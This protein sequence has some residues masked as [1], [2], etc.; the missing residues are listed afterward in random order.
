MRN[1][2]V[3]KKGKLP[4]KTLAVF[5]GI[6]GNEKVGI[7]ALQKI[8]KKIKIKKGIVYFVFANPPA[9]SKNKRLVNKNLN[10][11]FFKENNDTTFEDKRARQLMSILDRCDALLD[12]HS[13]NSRSGDQFAICEPKAYPI[14]RHMNFPIVVSG[15]SSIG[16]GTDGY[17]HKVGKIGI[18]IECGTTNKAKKFTPLAIQSVYQFLQY[19]GAID[20]LVEMNTAVQLYLSAKKI[21]H[22]KTKNFAFSKKFKDFEKL[23]LGNI[24]AID[25]VLKHRAGKDEYILF[26][27]ENG[28]IGS[29][30]CVICTT[31]NKKKS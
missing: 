5:A 19:Y 17:M 16:H 10:R 1:S 4:G 11:L 25:G 28:K 6:H 13:Y 29:E 3:I 12:I 27:R 24:F 15:F 31:L 14:L 8:L 9:I 20:T 18:C 22:K 23:K 26:P 30:V 7:F 21:L 2:I